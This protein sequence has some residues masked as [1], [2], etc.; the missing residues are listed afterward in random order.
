[1]INSKAVCDQEANQCA[2]HHRAG[3]LHGPQQV[4]TASWSLPDH[5]TVTF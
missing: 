3:M 4:T 1:M 2:F 5:S